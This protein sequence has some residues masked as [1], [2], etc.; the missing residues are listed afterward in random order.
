MRLFSGQ[1]NAAG[2]ETGSAP[3]GREALRLRLM[4][5]CERHIL[6]ETTEQPSDLDRRF[7]A[8]FNAAQRSGCIGASPDAD[9]L[10]QLF[11]AL[12][13][14]LDLRRACGTPAHE[15]RDVAA[16]AIAYIVV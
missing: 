7:T 15:L 3:D 4:L 13:L 1:P 14:T 9:T 10:A 11:I 8:F 6:D 16:A 2:G 12:L 5:Y